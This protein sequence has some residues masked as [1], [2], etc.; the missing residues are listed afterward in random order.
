MVC[1]YDT[2]LLLLYY[3]TAVL[4][5]LVVALRFAQSKLSVHVHLD[6]VQFSPV[7]KI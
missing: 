2:A 5:L 6:T 3:D 1:Y 7:I 4:L